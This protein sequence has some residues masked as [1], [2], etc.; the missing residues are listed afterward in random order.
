M[1][2]V[3]VSPACSKGSRLGH[4]GLWLLDDAFVRLSGRAGR[5]KSRRVRPQ[6]GVPIDLDREQWIEYAVHWNEMLLP[7][8]ADVEHV[9]VGST[10]SHTTLSVVLA[11]GARH[12]LR[13]PFSPV[14]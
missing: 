12:E 10:R 2:V 11:G 8:F 13:C 1:R 7:P 5:G 4:G 9:Q 3:L 6:P 14:T